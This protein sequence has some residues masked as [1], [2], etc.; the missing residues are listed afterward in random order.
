VRRLVIAVDCDNVLVPTMPFFIDTYNQKYGTSITLDQVHDLDESIWQA[1]DKTR[2]ERLSSL[3]LT[4]EYHK[5]G[6]SK[7][8]VDVLRELAKQHE[9]HLVTSRKEHEREFTQ[10]M[11]DR[12][13][14]GVFTSM[15]FVGWEGSKG[16]VCKRVGADV[17]IDDNIYH[18]QDA[19]EQGLPASGA[20]L[21]GD[22]PWNAGDG[23]HDNLTRCADWSQVKATVEVIA[24]EGMHVEQ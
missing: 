11:L 10:E 4:D 13:L 23:T 18:L 22:Y 5:L 1:D 19:I 3:T 21:F 8:E 7:E 16:E 2:I 20:I 9:L 15:E 24:K 14:S 12:E 6:P 17:L